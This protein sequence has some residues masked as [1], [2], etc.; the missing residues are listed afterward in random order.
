MSSFFPFLST[1]WCWKLK[2]SGMKWQLAITSSLLS[3]CHLLMFYHRVKKK[4]KKERHEAKS[5]SVEQIRARER[6]RRLLEHQSW[7]GTNDLPSKHGYDPSL[8]TRVVGACSKNHRWDDNED[9]V[10]NSTG[11]S[12]SLTLFLCDSLRGLDAQLTLTNHPDPEYSPENVELY[13]QHRVW[14]HVKKQWHLQYSN[15]MNNKWSSKH[16][17]L[18]NSELIIIERRQYCCEQKSAKSGMNTKYDSS[19]K[20]EKAEKEKKT[21]LRSPI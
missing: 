14:K 12:L 15:A 10:Q 21:L 9:H 5:V 20:K 13:F 2:F 19:L 3:S 7:P 6:A 11:L 8:W 1:R 17:N 16:A 18:N 4:K